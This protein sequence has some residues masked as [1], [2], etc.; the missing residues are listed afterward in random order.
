MGKMLDTV[1]AQALAFPLL[2]KARMGHHSRLETGTALLAV[3]QAYK[4]AQ[5]RGVPQ[6]QLEVEAYLRQM[7]MVFHVDN[8]NYTV[9]SSC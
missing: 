1:V 5:D 9:D 4:A 7:D 6:E 8:Q 3:Y 2:H